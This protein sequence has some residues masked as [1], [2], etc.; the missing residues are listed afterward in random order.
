MKQFF[1]NYSYLLII[2]FFIIISSLTMIMCGDDY[3]WFYTFTDDRLT[4][5]RSENGRYLTNFITRYIISSDILFHF[6]YITFFLLL[7]I[8]MCKLVDKRVKKA[9]KYISVFVLINLIPATVY[10]QVIRWKSAFP[11]YCLGAV[12]SFIFIIFALRVLFDDY[13]PKWIISLGFVVLGFAGALCVEHITLYNIAVC[14]YFFIVF[15]KHKKSVLHIIPFFV[16]T[17]SGAALMF[18]HPQYHVIATEGDNLGMR[19]FNFSLSDVL[20]QVY[21]YIIPSFCRNFTVIHLIVTVSFVFLFFKTPD[22]KKNKYNMPCVVICILFTLYSFFSSSLQGLVNLSDSMKSSSIE[23]AFTFLYFCALIYNTFFYLNKDNCIRA[24][25]FLLSTVV[26]TAPFL[27]VSPVTYRCFFNEYLFWILY[28]L[29]ISF[30]AFKDSSLFT[31][32]FF[33]KCLSWLACGILVIFANMNITN[34]YYNSVR[35]DYIRE[36][37]LEKKKYVD[38][39]LLPY[40]NYVCDDLTAGDDLF[41]TALDNGNDASYIEYIMK[42]YDIPYDSDN[43]FQFKEI[44]VYDYNLLM[45]SE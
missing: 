43:P 9:T 18:M 34:C 22:T 44:S 2:S 25:L 11:N 30:Y 17:L 42:Y 20:M 27:F 13:K 28:S 15:I 10:Q 14:F 39:I 33:E 32:A 41:V 26:L 8:L 24:L 23:L 7:I 35:Y 29:E 6:F 4:T 19:N 16:G 12:F 21:R 38:A 45:A 40:H 3:I 31:S 37:V 36:Q 5:H 1:R